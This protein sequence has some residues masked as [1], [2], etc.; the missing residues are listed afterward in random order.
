MLLKWF[1]IFLLNKYTLF[2]K[3]ITV[4]EVWTQESEG[5]KTTLYWRLTRSGNAVTNTSKRQL[6]GNTR[7]RLFSSVFSPLERANNSVLHFCLKSIH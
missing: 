5:P 7:R 1:D 6:T 4:Y 2:F 3:Y